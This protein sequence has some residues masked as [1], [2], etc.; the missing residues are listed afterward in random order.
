MIGEGLPIGDLGFDLLERFR[1]F[2]GT[3]EPGEGENPFAPK[4]FGV[5]RGRSEPSAINGDRS[6][7]RP[8]HESLSRLSLSQKKEKGGAGETVFERFAQWP[9]GNET[10]IADPG[11]RVRDK[12]GNILVKRRILKAVIHNEQRR[13]LLDRH[14]RRASSLRARPCRRLGCEEERLVSD[15]R[16]LMS[17]GLNAQDSSPAPAIAPR[18]N[19]GTLACLLEFFGEIKRGR[20]F[21][22]AA[23]LQIPNAEDGNREPRL[24]GQ[25]AMERFAER[26]DRRE[27]R[28]SESDRLRAF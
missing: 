27:W 12:N 17:V 1:E 13:A 5:C 18:E 15:I 9:C 26:V 7:F 2:F 16:A 28:E 4:F 22:R 23:D 8:L 14:L 19:M 3:R 25:G 20:R 21:A 6:L 11:F 24:L 10:A